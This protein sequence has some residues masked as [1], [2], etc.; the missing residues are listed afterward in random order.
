MVK[1]L[2]GRNR[3]IQANIMDFYLRIFHL[4]ISLQTRHLTPIVASQMPAI[5][6][7]LFYGNS[8]QNKARSN[9]LLTS[10]DG[11]EKRGN[12]END[13]D[14]NSSSTS[15]STDS[16]EG[17]ANSNSTSTSTST[18]STEGIDNSNSTSTSTS[19][20]STES[21]DYSGFHFLGALLPDDV[22]CAVADGIMDPVTMVFIIII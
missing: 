17:I 16:T 9:N 22:A 21:I 1:Y 7:H 10:V 3:D 18:D 12:Y 2:E 6:D 19:T 8:L 13:D 15:T 11:L 4:L 14:S 5:L 20:D